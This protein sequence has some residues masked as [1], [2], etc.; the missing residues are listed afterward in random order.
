MLARTSTLLLLLAALTTSGC[1]STQVRN[2]VTIGALSGAALGAGTGWLATDPDA[3]GSERGRGQGDIVLSTSEGVG[4]GM[5]VGAVVG[6]VVGG[7]VGH[8]RENPYEPPPKFKPPTDPEQ[9][10]GSPFV[11]GL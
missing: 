10:A 3:L 9:A 5:L 8:Q 7:M 11:R 2:G 6:A 4:V 1:V